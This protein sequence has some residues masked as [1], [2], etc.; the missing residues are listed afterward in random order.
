GVRQV[1]GAEGIEERNRLWSAPAEV[2][3][4]D[5]PVG[6]AAEFVAGCGVEA[7]PDRPKIVGFDGAD[8]SKIDVCAAADPPSVGLAD[9]SV[10]LVDADGDRIEVVALAACGDATD[11]EHHAAPVC[12]A[13]A[14][15]PARPCTGGTDHGRAA[16]PCAVRP[17]ADRPCTGAPWCKFVALIM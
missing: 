12:S 4:A 10:V 17:A 14:G 11:D 5:F 9:A 7:V 16:E 8:E 1:L 6:E 2:E 15:C 3:A 13:S